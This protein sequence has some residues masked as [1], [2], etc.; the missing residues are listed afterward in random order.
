VLSDLKADSETRDIPV[1]ICSIME[2]QERG[3]SL[4][5]ADYLLK[6]IIQDDLLSALDNLNG[7]GSIRAVL[8]VDDDPSDL[9]LIEKILKEH[10]RY[11]AILADSGPKGW[12]IIVSDPPHAVI[13]DLFMPD[14]DGFTILEKMREDP[15]LRSIPV[16][17]VSGVDLTAEQHEQLKQFGQRLLTKGTL[18]ESELLNTIE[19][20]LKRVRRTAGGA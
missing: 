16:V 20:A 2:E 4:G 19:Q 7:D 15:K 18:N 9:R 17:V 11:K 1:V 3:Y 5:A 10:G 6:P 14:M 8:V 13:L 12:D